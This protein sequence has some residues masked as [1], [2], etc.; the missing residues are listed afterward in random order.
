LERFFS[1]N[2]EILLLFFVKALQVSSGDLFLIAT[3]EAIPNSLLNNAIAL[4]AYLFQHILPV[5]LPLLVGAV[6]ACFFLPL[7]P[8]R[9]RLLIDAMFL[10]VIIRVIISFATMNLMILLP[11]SNLYL[12]FSQLL[13]FLPC[14]LLVWGWIYWRIDTY[15]VS[16]GRGRI[17]TSSTSGDE[18]P[19]PSDYFIASF[20]SLLTLALDKFSGTT[21]FAQTLILLH[22]V[23]M[24]DVLATSLSRAIALAL[25]LS[26]QHNLFLCIDP[27]PARQAKHHFPQELFKC[28]GNKCFSLL[29]VGNISLS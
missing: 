16:L 19:P 20:T 8:R 15:S 22:G 12:L 7:S 29:P 23:M 26:R 5:T 17:F 6:F 10:L 25:L 2:W 1:S 24:W 18:I 13:L 3:K 27:F 9:R 14:F 21:R 28:H 4:H 11:A